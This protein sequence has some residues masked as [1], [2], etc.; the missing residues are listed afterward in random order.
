MGCHASKDFHANQVD[1]SIHAMLEREKR[2]A[3][4]R[5]EGVHGYRPR[6]PHPLL[7]RKKIISCEEEDEETTMVGSTFSGEG[8]SRQLS[9]ISVLS[10][11]ADSSQD[12][13]QVQQVTQEAC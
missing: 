11:Q 8:G 2:L 13:K 9:D 5:G 10:S 7:V 12:T 6:D 4:K 1:D 3:M